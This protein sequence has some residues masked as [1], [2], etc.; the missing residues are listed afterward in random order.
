[1]TVYF[2]LYGRGRQVS[3]ASA[4]KLIS[5]LISIEGQNIVKE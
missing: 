1:M 2:N 5:P 3:L 4:Q